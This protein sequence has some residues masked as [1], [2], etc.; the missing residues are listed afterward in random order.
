MV[1]ATTEEFYPFIMTDTLN[2]LPHPTPAARP[3]TVYGPVRSWRYGNSLGI[4]PI[5]E[6]STC[7]FSC[8]YCQ[9]GAIQRITAERR[10]YVPTAEVE[11]DLAAVNWDA[12]DIVTISGSGEPTLAANLGEMIA[13][14]KR[15]TDKPVLVLSNS[16]LL[17]LP[18][19]RQQVLDADIVECKL[20]A[21]TD[22][23]LR[24]INRPAEGVTLEKIIEGIIALR[25]E[26]TGRLTLQVM[27]MPMNIK[28]VE[29]WIPII[30]A[31]QPAEV[32]LNT[33][34]RPFPMEWYRESRGDHES[35]FFSGAK[36]MLRVVTREEAQAAEDL[37][38]EHTGVSISSVYH[39]K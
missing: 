19:V 37:L 18:E 15:F 8:I 1:I 20:D 3:S 28:Q 12:V 25:A 11:A 34:R 31:I 9:L 4:D 30:Q 16:T 27:L 6:I 17:H 7:S 39:D 2:P 35:K 13:A 33:P 23:L 24:M 26:F 5:V 36:R 14:I 10:V 38:R 21:P 22:E 29:F 32:H